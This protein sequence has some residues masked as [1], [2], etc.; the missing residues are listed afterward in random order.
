MQLIFIIA[1]GILG[2]S[3]G[4]IGQE[5]LGIVAGAG[6]GYLFAQRFSLQKDIRDLRDRVTRLADRPPPDRPV[7]AAPKPVTEPEPVQRPLAPIASESTDLPA[8]DPVVQ[9]QPRAAA[10]KSTPAA[11][12]PVENIIAA[13]KRWLTT[14]NVPVKLGVI[15]SFFGVAFLLKYAVDRQMLIVPIEL[16]YLGVAMGAGAML[17]FGWRLRSKLR[18]YALSLQ[19]GGIGVLFLTIFAAFRLHPLLPA[20][21]AFFL[22]IALTA[23]A[24]VLAVLQDARAL[25]VLGIVGGFLAPVLISTGSGN[26]VGLFSYYLLLNAAIL[27]IAWFRAWRFLNVI[28]FVFTFGVGTLW[29]FKY[30]KPELFASTEPFLIAYFVFYQAIAILFA[31]R[32]PPKLRGVVDGTLIFGTPVIAFALQSQLVENTEYGLAISSIAVAIFYTLIAIWLH[33]SQGKQMRLLIESFIALGVAFATIA[34]PLALDGRWT[35]T[36]WALE[37]AALVWVGV[38]QQG[39]L[40]KLTGAALLGAAGIAYMNHGWPD[41]AGMPILNGDFLGGMLIGVASL[42]SARYLAA[43]KTPIRWQRLMSVPLL[44]WGLGWWGCI[45]VIEIMQQGLNNYRLHMITVFIAISVGALAWIARRFDWTAARRATLAYLPL[46]PIVAVLYLLDDK[47]FFAG[48]GLLAWTIATIAHFGLLRAYD[49][50]RGRI[51]G[52]WH[53]AGALFLVGLFA[54]EIVWRMDEAGFSDVWAISCALL[55]PLAGAMLIVYARERFA[56][57]L[58][59]YWTA[60]L[61]AAGILISAQLLLVGAAGID[62]AGNPAP[63]PYVPVLNPFDVLTIVGLVVALRFLLIARSTSNWLDDN[64]DRGVLVIWALAAF[65]LT[66][67]SVV[68]GVH[69]FS[70]V[71]WHESAL[72]SSVF[73][74]SA[75]SI[76]WAILG[77]SGM[78]WGAR[79]TNRWIW[80]AGTALMALVVIKLFLVDLGNTGTVARIVSFLG[81]GVLLLVVGYLAPAPPRKPD[82]DAVVAK[83]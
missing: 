50:G 49:N 23:F 80:L 74:Q 56:W 52:A 53:F 77:F 24:G 13:A 16:R 61:A 43:D 17:A 40:A 69:H 15:V 29:G 78:I 66:T 14:G 38:R 58:Q 79:R 28:G 75:L 32:Q 25:A 65:V 20:P 48:F 44:V 71:S 55:M 62:N 54:Y 33:K 27:G 6:I 81:V 34:I 82:D 36:A 67:I 37:G 64:R 2:L 46:L 9:S 59:R 8:P 41:D 7:A 35:A 31:F 12:S 19:G 60:Y 76:Y 30:Y 10:A 42:F 11:P 26:H 83:E 18:V 73:V 70:S 47:Q 3:L 1:G 68:R 4:G 22:L 63:L 57:P 51:E 72:T 21:F 45:G 5:M 39:L